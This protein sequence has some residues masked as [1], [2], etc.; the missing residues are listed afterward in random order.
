MYWI[1]TSLCEA[2]AA[3]SIDSTVDCHSLEKLRLVSRIQELQEFGHHTLVYSYIEAVLLRMCPDQ[4]VLDSLILE[5]SFL[6]S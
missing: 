6:R 3:V 5:A 2:A 4:R 1:A